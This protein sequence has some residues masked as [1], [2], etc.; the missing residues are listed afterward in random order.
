MMASPFAQR[1]IT[2]W[3]AAMAALVVLLASCLATTPTVLAKT[4]P[5]ASASASGL[6]SPH[7][8]RTPA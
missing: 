8:P 6:L 1:R 2:S 4:Y 7:D 3:V 5:G